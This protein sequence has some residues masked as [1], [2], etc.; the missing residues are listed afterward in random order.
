[1]ITGAGELRAAGRH[2]GGQLGEEARGPPPGAARAASAFL[3]TPAGC[4]PRS[5]RIP[6]SRRHE[7]RG[8]LRAPYSLRKRGIR[9]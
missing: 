6:G 8:C 1:M 7:R 5:Q 3:A 2:R 9:T 4:C